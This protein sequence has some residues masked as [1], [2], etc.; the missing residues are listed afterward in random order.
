[1]RIREYDGFYGM[2]GQHRGGDGM[3][4]WERKGTRGMRLRETG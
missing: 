4:E 2:S 3:R 1:M